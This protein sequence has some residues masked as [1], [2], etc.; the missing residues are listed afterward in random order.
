[1]WAFAIRKAPL[2][3]VDVTTY[4]VEPIAYSP[5]D[6]YPQGSIVT[7]SM[8]PVNGYVPS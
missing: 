5:T 8:V 2:R 3:A 6:E 7:A 4:V 1:M